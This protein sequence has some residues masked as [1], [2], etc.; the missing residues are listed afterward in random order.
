M[1]NTG[2]ISLN[3]P[4]VGLRAFEEKED[5]LFF[6]RSKQISELLKK[7]GE[8]RFL[9]VI[10]SSGS[11]KSSLVKSG[12]L[13]AIY[14]GFMTIGSNWRVALMR[15]GE[16]PVGYLAKEL[17]SEGTLYTGTQTSYVPYKFIIESSLRR[18]ENGLVQAYRDA[19][20][21][22][23]EN[24]L[25]VVDQ[26]EEL[27]RFSRYEKDHK[28]G[29]SDAIHFIQILL[30]AIRQKEYPVYVLLTMR[31]DFLGDCAEFR[32]LP[33]AINEGQYLVPRMIRDEIREAITGPVAVSSATITQR[34]VTRLLNDVNN[35]T[36][37]LP[38]LQHAMMRTWDAW[39][40]RN[41]PGTP[42][43][44]EDYE[45]IGTME[46]ALSQHADEAYAD[47]AT[48]REQHLCELMF[49]ALTDSAADIR[50]IRRPRSVADLVLITGG[51][52]AEMINQVEIFRKPGRTF[53]M[54]PLGVQL[55]AESIVDISHESL[56]R[57]W[58]RLVKW[59]EEEARS[60]DIYLRLAHSAKLNEQGE[61]GLL[62]NP[63]LEIALRWKEKNK[64]NEKWAEGYKVNFE[65]AMIYL[66]ESRKADRA[67][68]RLLARKEATRRRLITVIFMMLGLL[69]IASFI[70]VIYFNGLKQEAYRQKAEAYKQKDIADKATFQARRSDSATKVALAD[71]LKSKEEADSSADIAKQKQQEA[72]I[73]ATIANTKKREA[74]SSAVIANEQTEKALSAKQQAD[75]LLRKTNDQKLKIAANEY[76]RLIREGP[77]DENKNKTEFYGNDYMLAYQYHFDQLKD[78]VAA[79]DMAAYQSLKN[80]LYYNND[81]YQ[82]I[83]EDFDKMDRRREVIREDKNLKPDIDGKLSAIN[84]SKERARINERGKLTI[85]GFSNANKGT[86]DA[87]SGTDQEF[88]SFAV[89]RN[90]QRIFCSTT[91]NLILVLDNRLNKIDV[92]NM[93][94][95]V[96]ALD[97]NEARSIIYF[98]TAGGDIGYIDYGRDKK[99]QPVFE[100]KLESEITALQVF[101]Y[102]LKDRRTN[103]APET[104]LLATG[105][106]SE[107]RVYKLDDNTVRPD[108]RLFGNILPYTE[109]QYGKIYQAAFSQETGLVTLVT[110][111]G[112]YAW[113]PFTYSLLD[114]LKAIR[115]FDP[116]TAQTKS[117]IDKPAIKFY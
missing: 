9:A 3:N 90:Q 83:C 10:G 16:D 54:P 80:K 72:N 47:L 4:F 63:E 17:A 112:T 26:F 74:D 56:M 115:R 13:P 96:T 58:E 73:S 18:S 40:K 24:L 93:G 50:G 28:P 34:L 19:R 2:A 97:F 51:T 78:L 36:D 81:L 41:Q 6:G 49:K 86:A 57:V 11:G 102:A 7:F 103:D 14:S 1:D 45:K 101:R 52:Q 88:I 39:Y 12:L 67:E 35:D 15:P 38:I 62:K 27:F 33:E 111:T 94:A 85:A 43:D 8:S 82:R 32:G 92:I 108:F 59:T 77:A 48:E 105:L 113:N 104:F 30:T 109:K 21:D 71:A 114:R 107:P 87:L 29:Q 61:R 110:S 116:S 117:L 84:I 53:L 69:V 64:P 76:A 75:N 106:R 25:I 95:K 5:Y 100:N 42:I 46:S 66:E 20:L 22:P 23:R 65:Q 31:S 79:E 70:L 37:Q 89:S 91:D 44:F 55:T 60:G 98:G 99:N 68:K